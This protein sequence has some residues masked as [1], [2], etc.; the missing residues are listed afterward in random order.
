MNFANNKTHR[1]FFALLLFLGPASI[2]AF[3][4]RSGRPVLNDVEMGTFITAY[5]SDRP[6]VAVQLISE[7]GRG[8]SML[9]SLRDLGADV[10]S[11]DEK[12]GYALVLLPREKFMDAL[13]L[14]DVLHASALAADSSRYRF[15][16]DTSYVP[17]SERKPKPVG[18]ISIPVPKVGTSLPKDGP[19]F[20]A[21]D[22]GLLALWK[23]HP[24]ADGRGVRVAVVDQGL[25]LLHPCIQLAK[26]ADGNT[27]PKVADIMT[28]SDPTKSP[29]WVQ[30]GEPI[31]VKNG[32]FEAAGRA[33]KVPND[34]SYRFGMFTHEFYLGQFRS[35]E[36]DQ[37]PRLKKAALSVGVLWDEKK[38]RIWVDTDGAGD[39]ANH[40]ALGDYSETHDIDWFGRKQG[41]NDN[42]IPFG[43]KIDRSKKA[44]YLSISTGS[45]G[46]LVAG[47]LAANKQTGGLFDGA[48][49]NAQLIDVVFQP[50]WPALLSAMARPDV[51]VINVSGGIGRPLDGGRDDFYRNLLTRA[52]ETYK[53]PFAAC[54]GAPNSFNVLDYA[55]P[56]LLRRN[57]QTSPPYVEYINGGVFFCP[58]GIV[59]TIAA[60]SAQ[61]GTESRYMP[62]DFVS[63]DGNRY[64][65]E[66]K[67]QAFAP[68]GYSIGANPS[69]TIPVVSGV[70]ADIISEAKRQ[71]IRFDGARLTQAV[72]TGARWIRGIPS[73]TQGFGLVNAAGAWEQLAK[74]AKADDPDNP[75]LTS[76]I[77]TR[78]EN[79]KS[80]VVNGFQADLPKAGGPFAGE[81]WLTRIGGYGG[82]RDYEL[83]VRGDD[84]TY[85]ILDPKVSFVR[86]RPE[87]VRFNAKLTGGLHVGF[88]QLKDVKASV[89]MQEVPLSVRVPEVLEE[90]TPFVEKYRQTIPVRRLETFY[91]RVPPDTQAARYVMRI[92]FAGAQDLFCGLP[93]NPAINNIAPTGEPLDNEHHVGPMQNIEMVSLNKGGETKEIYWSNRGGAEYENPSDPPAPTVPIK[94]EL[95][96]EKFAVALDKAEQGAIRLTNLQAD[97]SGW[98]E[99]YD[100]KVTSKEVPGSGS[101]ALAIV[102][103]TLPAKLVQW[104]VAVASES[105]GEGGVD[106]FLLDC[107]SKSGCTV[108]DVKPVTRSGAT[109]VVDNPTEGNWRIVLRARDKVQAPISYQVREALLT[110][111]AAVSPETRDKEAKHGSGTKWEV[112]VPAKSGDAQYAAFI[113]AGK[114]FRIL[115]DFG[116]EPEKYKFAWKSIGVPVYTASNADMR[117]ALT[118]LTEGSP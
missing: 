38:S 82:G 25:D 47:P 6:K 27:V 40:K 73:T 77:A 24:N 10:E 64:N 9:K 99:F 1:L 23:E 66:K 107:T 31:E 93:G 52:L 49:P 59:N 92:P 75:V 113:I 51:D 103:R 5:F 91:I 110:L 36:K 79:G 58:D 78:K 35:W 43:V 45:H 26:D 63:E 46:A 86:D 100:A 89:V 60:P 30:F 116:K 111:S 98:V 11:S 87:R 106:A 16:P 96:V 8:S 114:P 101:H 33:W 44:A 3:A 74:M 14:P 72:F 115:D 112:N 70:L 118:P 20:A 80:R 32:S 13:D 34:G 94:A 41:E 39:F 68:P 108:A 55:G 104:R 21:E 84:G 48:A 50:Y 54:A 17:L 71:H 4:Q 117:I 56:E 42:R 37:D 97:I 57:R 61:L 81:L 2:P 19:Y 88:L 95:R 90:E 18:D 62:Y 15:S 67:L 12:V 53:K 28:F 65:Q 22:A 102:D 109:L 83:S 105:I 76:F 69:P 29:L 85:E 7:A